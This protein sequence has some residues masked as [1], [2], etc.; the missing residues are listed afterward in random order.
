MENKI[1]NKIDNTPIKLNFTDGKYATGKRKESIARVWIKKGTGNIFVNNK[2]M[3]DYFKTQKLRM[4]VSSP[5]SLIK[6][7]GDF[8]IKCTVKGGGLSGQ[9]GA[10]IHGISKAL[11]IEEPELKLVLKKA[12]FTTRDSRTVERKKYGR[13]K[14]RRSFQFS[15][16]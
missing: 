5:L 7:E 9:A 11:V 10:I 4:V 13:R 8:D 2:K 15:K 6:R 12:K 3:I 14:A 16:R 1:E